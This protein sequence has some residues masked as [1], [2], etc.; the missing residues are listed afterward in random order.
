M[1]TLPDIKDVRVVTEKY[2]VVRRN[3]IN[4]RVTTC[5]CDLLSLLSEFRQLTSIM[6]V[7]RIKQI[8]FDSYSNEY[9]D[10]EITVM[11]LGMIS[12]EPD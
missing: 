11:P 7:R 3:N 1:Q 2:Q 4:G 6:G 5:Q 8:V 12:F 9:G 10:C